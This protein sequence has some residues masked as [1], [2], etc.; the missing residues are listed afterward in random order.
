MAGTVSGPVTFTTAGKRVPAYLREPLRWPAAGTRSRRVLTG[1]APT[2]QATPCP[3][4][5]RDQDAVIRT[6]LTRA[7]DEGRLVLVGGD[8]TV[9]PTGDSRRA[10]AGFGTIRN[11]PLIIFGDQ[12]ADVRVQV[13][14][15]D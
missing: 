6:R 5:P 2:N 1:H 13:A 3:Y 14:L 9:V 15:G 7:A 12:H 8:S 10:R 4:V 11:R